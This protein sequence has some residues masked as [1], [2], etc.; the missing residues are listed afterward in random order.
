MLNSHVRIKAFEQEI[1]NAKVEA[2]NSKQDEARSIGT[3]P[4]SQEDSRKWQKEARLKGPQEE[5]DSEFPG[6]LS[7][8]VS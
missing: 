8:F 7:L 4:T 1:S 6:S 5:Y 2:S 3:S